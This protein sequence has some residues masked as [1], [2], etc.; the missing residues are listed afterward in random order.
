MTNA[1]SGW[2]NSW[3]AA[4][5][6]GAWAKQNKEAALDSVYLCNQW[7][8][9][10]GRCAT[11]PAPYGE[12]LREIEPKHDDVYKYSVMDG[13]VIV[14]TRKFNADAVGMPERRR[15]KALQVA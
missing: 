6:K 3:R 5:E 7:T 15:K 12:L 1:S 4:T 9:R 8:S 13:T 11:K 10:N 2:S 14:V